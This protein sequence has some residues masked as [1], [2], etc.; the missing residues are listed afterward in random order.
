MDI[1]AN[2]VALAIAY[3][4]DY[5]DEFVPADEAQDLLELIERLH[6]EIRKLVK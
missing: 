6:V 5:A 1:E 2:D 3:L 4:Q